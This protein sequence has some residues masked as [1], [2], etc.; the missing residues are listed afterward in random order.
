MLSCSMAY[1]MFLD[2]EL[3]RRPLHW[4]ANSQPLYRQGSPQAYISLSLVL[5]PLVHE[6]E[7]VMGGKSIALR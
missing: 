6:G 2:Q 3:N 5:H 4:Q 7:S 1:G